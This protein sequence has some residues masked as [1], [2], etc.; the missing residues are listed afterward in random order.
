MRHQQ[1][2]LRR[3]RIYAPLRKQLLDLRE[4]R[5][6]HGGHSATD[7]N[8]IGI[9]QVDDVSQPNRQ[10]RRSLLQDFASYCISG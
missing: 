9:E 5:F 8:H 3:A 7:H 6:E 10:Q 1:R 4:E 2:N